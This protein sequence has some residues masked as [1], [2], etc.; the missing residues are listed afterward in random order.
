MESLQIARKTSQTLSL[1][2]NGVQP[3]CGG[4]H[5]SSI[6]EAA[7]TLNTRCINKRSFEAVSIVFKCGIRDEEY[8]EERVATVDFG[9]CVS[10]HDIVEA[11][12]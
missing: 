8:G 7:N 9:G 10:F 3:G 12:L 5:H 11:C 1:K 4:M 2:R 6:K